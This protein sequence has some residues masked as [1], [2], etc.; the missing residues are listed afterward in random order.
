M[1]LKGKSMGAKYFYDCIISTTNGCLLNP[2]G[3]KMIFFEGFKNSP[4]SNLKIHT[5]TFFTN[6]LGEPAG[7]KST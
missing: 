2:E 4:N 5:H 1:S 3:S 6:H 7:F